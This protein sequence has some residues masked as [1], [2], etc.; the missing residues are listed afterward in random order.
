MILFSD[1]AVLQVRGSKSGC[2]SRCPCAHS[3]WAALCSVLSGG[4]MTE[5]GGVGWV[6]GE[7]RTELL[8]EG[9]GLG[10]GVNLIMKN[11]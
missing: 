5:R 6:G 2:F 4:R 8:V 11:E 7:S 9:V 1:L 3:R 10:L